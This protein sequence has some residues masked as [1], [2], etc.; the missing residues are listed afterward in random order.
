VISVVEWWVSLLAALDLRGGVG[1][2][3]AVLVA[4]RCY[5][6]SAVLLVWAGRLSVGVGL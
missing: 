1:S 5:A 6:L 2:I 4:D 3:D